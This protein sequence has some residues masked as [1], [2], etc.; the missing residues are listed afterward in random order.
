MNGI[1]LF[2]SS[3]DFI[4]LSS[5]K[6]YEL[7]YYTFNK[8][9]KLYNSDLKDIILYKI[10]TDNIFISIKLKNTELIEPL[11]KCLKKFEE[12]EEYEKCKECLELINKI[13]NL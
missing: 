10:K 7:N 6:R 9:K 12:F 5:S 1:L 13:I 8:I 4:E 3:S 2:N 11:Y